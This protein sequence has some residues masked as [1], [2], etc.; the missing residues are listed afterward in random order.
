[1]NTY[2]RDVF[3]SDENHPTLNVCKN[4]I[5]NKLYIIWN[6]N[7][8]EVPDDIVHNL[9]NLFIYDKVEFVYPDTNS[10]NNKFS[11]YN[12]I[13]SNCIL[14]IDDDYIITNEAIEKCYDIWV[15][16]NDVLVGVVP[17]FMNSS[18]Y[19]GYATNKI[20]TYKY[21]MILTG[22]AMFDKKYLLLYDNDIENKFL[23]DD[24]FNGED[25][26]FNFVHKT[27]SNHKPIY[28]HDDNI[29]TWKKIK[30]NSISDNTNHMS[31]RFNIF[32]K[33]YK[34]YGDIL[35]ENTDKIILNK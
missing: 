3:L 28:V 16:N 22:C 30:N 14:T 20:N 1:M 33:M 32:S 18:I 15:E 11:I 34:K 19:N 31:K 10:L 21:N 13:E 8:R 29:R 5:V 26:I 24:Y 23:V 9:K 2:N 12:K 6:N 27:Y 35:I 17:R 7:G 4:K 25:I